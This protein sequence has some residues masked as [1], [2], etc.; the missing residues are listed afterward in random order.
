MPEVVEAN[1]RQSGALQERLEFQLGDSTPIEWLSGLGGEYESVSVAGAPQGADPVHLRKLAL[2][3]ALEG[4]CGIARELH[5]PPGAGRLR[6]R[7]DRTA[8][9]NG[10]RTTDLEGAVFEVYVIPLQAE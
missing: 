1:L 5:A 7:E 2:Q 9:G 6:G 4:L 8:L 10:E 3:V